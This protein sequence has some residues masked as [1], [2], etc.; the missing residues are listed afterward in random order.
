MSPRSNVV[1]MLLQRLQLFDD[2]LERIRDPVGEEARDPP[3]SI[4]PWDRIQVFVRP[5]DSQGM[6][7]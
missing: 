2:V 3:L 6:F 4:M 5:E 1:S 7:K